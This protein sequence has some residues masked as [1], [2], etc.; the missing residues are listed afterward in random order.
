MQKK[1]A[2][3]GGGTAGILSLT[4]F[5]TWLDNTWKVVSIHNPQKKILGIGESTN[6]GFVTLL[7]YGLDFTPGSPADM[8]RLDATL[9]FGSMFKKWRKH[10]FLNPLLDGST[11]IHFN[12]FN[13]REFA[14]ERLRQLWPKKFGLIEGDVKRIQNHP[15]RVTLTIDDEEH[16]FDYVID[17]MGFP[18]DYT[19][20]VMSDCTPINHCLIHNVREYEFEPYTDHIATQNGWMF[21][22]PLQGRKTYGYMFNDV[23]TRKEEALADMKEVLGVDAIDGREYF[24]KCYYAKQIIAGRICKN[25]NKALFFEPLVANSIFL[26]IHTARVF[27]DYIAGHNDAPVS[28]QMFVKGVQ[29]MEDLISHYYQGGSTHQSKFWDAAVKLT[30]ERLAHR[31]PY[32]ELLATYR[33]LHSEG[34]L[35]LGPTYALA[36][37]NWRI[38]DKALG[39]GNF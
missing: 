3:I 26:Y 5:C 13:F 10:D 19:D 24:F 2:V 18:E 34:T 17:C 7:Q 4:H 23:I 22:V 9:K 27:F 36:P 21:G 12:N 15:D 33:K 28:N 6:G 1:L 31:A 20:Y 29:D 35:H 38:I 32:H 11:A 25:G 37:H 30:Q 16:E 8:A 39:Y 14:Y